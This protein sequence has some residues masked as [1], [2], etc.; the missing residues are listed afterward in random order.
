MLFP[1]RGFSVKTQRQHPASQ[2]V[3]ATVR[4]LPVSLKH[5]SLWVTAPPNTPPPHSP[6]VVHTAPAPSLSPP[7]EQKKHTLLHNRAHSSRLSLD[8]VAPNDLLTKQSKIHIKYTPIGR[9]PRLTE[10]LRRLDGLACPLEVPVAHQPVVAAR[11]Q[12]TLH[13][14]VP[15]QAVPLLGVA[16]AP[17]LWSAPSRGVVVRCNNYNSKR[18]R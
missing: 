9:C 14:G 4:L 1:E 11:Q 3:A 16:L 2:P 17:V 5:A 6:Q 13:V 18:L 7:L 12:P 8:Y 15:A 10:F